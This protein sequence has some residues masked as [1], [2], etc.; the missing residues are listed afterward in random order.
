[1]EIRNDITAPPVHLNR[2]A[3]APDMTG[4]EVK[5]PRDSFSHGAAPQKN[6][7]NITA[8]AAGAILSKPSKEP[9]PLEKAAHWKFEAQDKHSIDAVFTTP[10]GNSY[11]C[12]E[13]FDTENR[14]T[15]RSYTAAFDPSGK[16]LWTYKT[17]NKYSISSHIF[18]PDG[19]SYLACNGEERWDR[20]YVVALNPDGT[21]KWKYQPKTDSKCS[22]IQIGPDGTIYAKIEKELHAIDSK[23]KMKWKHEIG[24][25]SDDYF[26]E[27]TPGGT[28]IFACD[29]FSNN[30]GYDSF[31]AVNS[32]GKKEEIDLPDIGTFPIN[33]GKG[34]IFYGGE[35]G[36]FYGID[37]TTGQKWELSL[38]S[39]RGLK[40][41]HWG[42][43][44]RIYVE[45]RFDN[46]LYAIDPQGKLIWKETIEDHRP[47]GMALD[48]FYKVAHD[49]SVFYAL[50][51]KD[52]IQV[53]DARG[54]RS[55]E[56]NVPGGFSEFCPDS[57]GHLYIRRADDDTIIFCDVQND[58]RF[59][60]PMELAGNMD[61]KEVL[62]DGTVVF[63]D[64]CSR[65]HVKFDKD[66][67]VKKY[68]EELQEA[69]DAGESQKPVDTI[70]EEDDWVYIGNVKI[71]KK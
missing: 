38:D 60:F 62:D 27:M 50:E 51:G 20:P 6:M 19:S 68:L 41:P 56:I 58:T 42:P 4:E 71:P 59:Y 37:T 3:G 1:M 13:S 9:V 54:N 57:R 16:E 15:P 26:H 2:P 46:A 23:G 34:H 31:Y 52:S 25:H 40:M 24:I 44:G 69:G 8:G 45:G 64:M 65:F 53:I 11:I 39:E 12:C 63:Q 28:S 43:D 33:D 55:K 18:L 7:K 10:N 66:E 36:E 29:N 14:D 47:G 48:E 49:G 67:E 61:M 5:A 35:K 32:K 30:F 70:V 22:S 17:D 21:E